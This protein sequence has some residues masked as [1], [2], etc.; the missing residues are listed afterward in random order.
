MEYCS[1]LESCF[2][3]LFY[4]CILLGLWSPMP[5][6][7]RLFRVICRV[8]T[9]LIAA[10]QV[11]NIQTYF[12]N[13][14]GRNVHGLRANTIFELVGAGMAAMALM[15]CVGSHLLDRSDCMTSILSQLSL[16]DQQLLSESQRKRTYTNS[17]RRVILL[18]LAVPLMYT[19]AFAECVIRGG[20]LQRL[21]D[22]Y[23]DMVLLGEALQFI[24]LVLTLRHRFSILNQK[25]MTLPL[26]DAD[27]LCLQKAH[28]TLTKVTT[29][30]NDIYGGSNILT[31]SQILFSLVAMAYYFRRLISGANLEGRGGELWMTTS[32]LVMLGAKLGFL[33]ACCH[34][35]AT[36]ASKTA[37]VLRDLLMEERR[38]VIRNRLRRF[39][40]QVDITKPTFEVWGLVKLDGELVG[41]VAT[42]ALM[43]IIIL[44]QFIISE[45]QE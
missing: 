5:S 43:F 17:R 45:N 27:L 28:M 7:T 30:V 23:L 32:V 22:V 6:D 40:L 31:V 13:I 18:L 19:F 14:I 26:R 20:D 35:T 37:S 44:L 12:V 10:F 29:V 16:V 8:L 36:E 41:R 39:E 11:A 1:D 21:V 42:S 4:T 2:T 25:I 38:T 34:L 3:P 9:L 24:L 15:W 33:A